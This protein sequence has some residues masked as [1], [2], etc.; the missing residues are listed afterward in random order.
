MHHPINCIYMYMIYIYIYTYI[1]HRRQ[2]VHT[3]NQQT[4]SQ[5]RPNSQLVYIYIQTTYT[6]KQHIHTNNI[7]I[8]TT[9]HASSQFVHTYIHNNFT[10]V[11]DGLDLSFKIV[12]TDY[13]YVAT[14]NQ[15]A[16]KGS[17]E[18]FGY[19]MSVCISSSRDVMSVCISSSR[20]VM[21]V[22]I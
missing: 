11:S 9:F 6:Y 22:C 20:D 3:P 4:C 5:K 16:R 13:G 8:Q 19:V 21:S 12:A 1:C 18:V 15:A 10:R 2:Y 17:N 14:A 7:Y